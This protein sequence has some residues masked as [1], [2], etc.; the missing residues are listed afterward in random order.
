MLLIDS[1]SRSIAVALPSSNNEVSGDEI[2]VGEREGGCRLRESVPLG[3][4]GV[5]VPD[6]G[7]RGSLESTEVRG[8]PNTPLSPPIA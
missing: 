3:V 5:L 2:K 8:I 4:T 7:R 6:V 1:A